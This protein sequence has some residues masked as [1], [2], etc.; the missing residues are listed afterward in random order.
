MARL[1]FDIRRLVLF[2]PITFIVPTSN[3]DVLYYEN[4]HEEGD[5]TDFKEGGM[6]DRPGE[7]PWLLGH[8][9]MALLKKL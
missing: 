5:R 6:F 2:N 7:A 4:T 8:G 3:S 9:A 1:N